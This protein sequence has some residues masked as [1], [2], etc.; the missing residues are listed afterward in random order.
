MDRDRI[1]GNLKEA[2]G[3]LTGDE[4]LEKEGQAQDSWGKA[5]DTAGDAWD[6]TKDAADDVKDTVDKRV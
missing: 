4:E 5:K 1:E 3:K 6:K 2:E